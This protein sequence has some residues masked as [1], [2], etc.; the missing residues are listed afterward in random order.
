MDQD[1]QAGMIAAFTAWRNASPRTAAEDRRGRNYS[2][3]S[4]SLTRANPLRGMAANG[5][6]LDQCT[7]EEIAEF[8]EWSE[9]MSD[10]K[11]RE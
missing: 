8:V 2:S 6:Q 11:R 1:K 10:A 9:Q 5:K 7:K 3:P 4:P